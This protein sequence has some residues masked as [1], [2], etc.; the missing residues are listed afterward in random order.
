MS[1]PKTN[2]PTHLDDDLKE[3]P[4][5]HDLKS[6]IRPD[7]VRT[8]NDAWEEENKDSKLRNRRS[9]L[10]IHLSEPFSPLEDLMT[11]AYERFGNMDSDSMDASVKRIMLR[12]ANLIV[13]D[14]RLHPYT[15]YPD[16]DYYTSLQDIR[17][18][19]DVI[20]LGG[21]AYHYA[22]WMDSTKSN[23]LGLEYMQTLNQVMYQR[24]YGSGKIEMN[25][26][27]KDDKR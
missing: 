18:I 1:A 19:P 12:Y 11:D 5:S 9:S 21:L 6:D 8:A 22:K 13:E 25:T 23:T 27:D 2:E 14:I 17:P 15:S 20:V 16:L 7:V 4:G 3:R 26:V 10:N 24:K